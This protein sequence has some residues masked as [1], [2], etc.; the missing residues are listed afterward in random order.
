MKYCPT[1]RSQYTD[2]TLRYCLQDG[3]TLVEQFGADTPTV[4]FAEN[5]TVASRK[6]AAADSEVTSWRS[7]EA[8]QVAAAK[9]ARAGLPTG[10]LAALVAVAAVLVF[11]VIAGGIGLWLYLAKGRTVDT[12]SNNANMNTNGSNLGNSSTYLPTPSPALTATPTTANANIPFPA[13][14]PSP[15]ST[16]TIPPVSTDSATQ[17]VS[18]KIYGWKSMV[19]SRNLDAYMGN[20]ADTVDYYRSPGSSRSFV[21]NDKARAFRL[22]SSMRI[23]ISNMRISVDESGARATAVFDKE[24]D[25][26]GSRTSSG[27]VQTQL[28]LRNFGGTWLITGER[29]LRVY[30]T[31]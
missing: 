30:Y 19:E 15:V 4:A 1:C 22:Y 3:A 2:E 28:T 10:P 8:T 17:E 7:E 26:R 18:Q 6:G 27:K 11:A 25:F 9:P 23:N 29:D 31:R 16:P 21:R 12:A 5:E 24:W 13:S 14:T 20:Y